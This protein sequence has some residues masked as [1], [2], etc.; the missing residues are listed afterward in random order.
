MLY[1]I[2]L[3]PAALIAAACGL[4]PWIP[5]SELFQDPMLVAWINGTGRTHYGI[6][7]NLGVLLWAFA[8][9][10]AFL[11]AIVLTRRGRR[12]EAGFFA[13]AAAL[14]AVLMADDLLMIHESLWPRHV[15]LDENVLLGAYGSALLCY[16]WAFRRDVAAHAAGVLVAGGAFFAF[17][18]VGDQ[19][20]PGSGDPSEAA[21]FLEDAAK[22]VGISCWA[23]FQA[24]AAT[25]AL[26]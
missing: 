8:S 25:R 9:S 16:A 24:S 10:V 22:L 6:V 21:V 4:Q 1:A 14:S 2:A 3:V 7:S 15:G 19:F 13:A 11:A 23:A 18:I 12:R 17:S 5:V 20:L 26:S